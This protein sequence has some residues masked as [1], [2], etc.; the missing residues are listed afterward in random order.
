MVPL[1]EVL[2][3]DFAMIR[4]RHRIKIADAVHLAKARHASASA[5]VTNDERMRPTARLEVARLAD[6]VE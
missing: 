2:A 6:L 4:G 5:I 3:I 1:I